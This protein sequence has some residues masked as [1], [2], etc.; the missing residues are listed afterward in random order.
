MLETQG[1]RTQQD[2]HRARTVSPK[3]TNETLEIFIRVEFPRFL[4]IFLDFRELQLAQSTIAAVVAFL[5]RPTEIELTGDI[6]PKRGS[7]RVQQYQIQET[8]NP[9]RVFEEVV[10]SFPSDPHSTFQLEL[11]DRQA[12]E[13]R[14]QARLVPTSSTKL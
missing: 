12:K 9:F 1:I 11:C 8:L 10:S 7:G 14:P 13:I 5:Q 3:F 6:N 2:I 4:T